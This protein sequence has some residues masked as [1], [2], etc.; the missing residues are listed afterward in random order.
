MSVEHFILGIAV[1]PSLRS[2]CRPRNVFR[3]PQTSGLQ[4]FRRARPGYIYF[5]IA[6]FER[7]GVNNN[8]GLI[9]GLHKFWVLRISGKS[10]QKPPDLKLSR[11]G[12]FVPKIGAIDTQKNAN[13]MA[14]DSSDDETTSSSSST[15]TDSSSTSSGDEQ[16]RP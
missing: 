1:R 10:P 9:P 5:H 13:N 15:S 8:Q 4:H 3:H 11:T 7:L 2:R 12:D 6:S 14:S 16:A